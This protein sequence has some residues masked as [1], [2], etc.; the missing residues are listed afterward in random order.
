MSKKKSDVFKLVVMEDD[1]VAEIFMYGILG[2]AQDWMSPS[3]AAKYMSDMDFLVTLRTLSKTN[4]R[5]NIR[6]NSPGGSMKHGLGMITA[7][8]SADVELHCYVDGIAA[9]MAADF[10]L[11]FKKEN[12]HMANNSILMIHT[13]IEGVYGNARDHEECATKL[14]QLAEPTI[15]ILAEATGKTDDEIRA[16][17][18]DYTDH[19]LTAKECVTIGIV[20]A[21]ENYEAAEVVA[22]PKK[23]GY[24]DLLSVFKVNNL[25]K[26]FIHQNQDTDDMKTVEDVVKAIQEGTLDQAALLASLG[27]EKIATPVPPIPTPTPEPIPSVDGVKVLELAVEKALKPLT[28]RIAILENKPNGS[29]QIFSEG[30][31][32]GSME[33]VKKKFEESQNNL[34]KTSMPFAVSE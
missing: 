14:K 23:M 32:Y 10:F 24:T 25:Q 20:S 22:D 21:V 16:E 7:V 27:A 2:E 34:A 5:I 18:Y 26:V 28:E 6:L 4:K 12:R 13:P 9:S 31:Q 17:F 3:E 19:Y 30:D 33:D 1:G 8:R 15:T 11:S 29:T